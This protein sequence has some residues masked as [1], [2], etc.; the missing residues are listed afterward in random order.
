M[1]DRGLRRYGRFYRGRRARNA[2]R[3]SP[4]IRVTGLFS[5]NR[6]ARPNDAAR[7]RYA[8]RRLGLIHRSISPPLH[9][10]HPLSYF[11]KLKFLLYLRETINRT[12]KYQRRF[13]SFLFY[14]SSLFRAIA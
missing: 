1:G 2:V 10:R 12:V 4:E 3:F 11:C 6:I 5:K 7:D 13:F 14:F 9:P 8:S